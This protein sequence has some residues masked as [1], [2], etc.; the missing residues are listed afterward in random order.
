MKTLHWAMSSGD[1]V[2][3]YGSNNFPYIEFPGWAGPE[4]VQAFIDRMKEH[5]LDDDSR[6]M[7]DNLIPAD[8]VNMLHKRLTGRFRPVTTAVPYYA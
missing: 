7:V 1:G 5:L 4:S 8:A 3:E 2:K 6:K